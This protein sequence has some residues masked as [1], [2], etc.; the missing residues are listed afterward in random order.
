VWWDPAALGLDKQPEG[1]IRQQRILAADEGGVISEEGVL[2]HKAWIERRDE[3]IRAGAVPTQL[4]RTATEIAE[5]TEEGGLYLPGLSTRGPFRA[6]WG[7]IG[8][9]ET[10][11]SRAHRPH[12]KRFGTLVHAVLAEV[13]LR[14]DEAQVTSVA[15]AQGRLLGAS[16][17][18]VSA[19]VL[20]VSAALQHSLLKRAAESAIAGGCRRETP[21]LLSLD[22]GGV[23]DL[24]F[25][26][27]TPQGATWTVVDFK[28]D[29]EL[30]GR[31]REYETQVL[32]YVTAIQRSTGEAA[33]GV[34]LAV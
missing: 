6:A 33:R 7:E 13:D 8:F 24:A 31:R 11:T 15:A 30:E 27:V 12:G 14:A 21:I 20:A 16:T 32:L 23:I 17:D 19:S 5:T 2:A 3:L 34:L 26:E 29:A 9:A 1:G 22:D 28:T 10:G 25:R 18:E 4:V